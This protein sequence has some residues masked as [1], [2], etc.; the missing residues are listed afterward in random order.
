MINCTASIRVHCSHSDCLTSTTQRR[1]QSRVYCSLL[2]FLRPF[3]D[4]YQW[5]VSFGQPSG[6]TS[7]VFSWL[8]TSHKQTSPVA[9]LITLTWMT[10]NLYRYQDDEWCKK[11]TTHSWLQNSWVSR[12]LN[13]RM[14]KCGF[15]YSII[16][17][18]HVQRKRTRCADVSKKGKSCIIMLH[19]A[20][21]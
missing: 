18:K 9:F 14:P 12:C 6:F 2:S 7:E 5:L 1:H 8:L 20:L 21:G 3:S 17:L 4:S 19:A 10:E 15:S 16:R 11:E 13:T